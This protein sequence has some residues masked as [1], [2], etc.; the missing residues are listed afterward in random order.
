M[1]FSFT[2][3]E[4]NHP[5]PKSPKLAQNYRHYTTEQDQAPLRPGHQNRTE[6]ITGGKLNQKQCAL[7][8]RRTKIQPLF[9]NE[10]RRETFIKTSAA[11]QG[12]LAG[13]STDQ[14][15]VFVE[16]S[17]E[18]SGHRCIQARWNFPC[19]FSLNQSEIENWLVVKWNSLFHDYQFHAFESIIQNVDWKHGIIWNYFLLL[20]NILI[21]E[22]P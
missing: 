22:P 12:F 11:C 9:V 5:Q 10:S 19:L 17:P 7:L 21:E 3:L 6:P 15:L 8:K 1:L 14:L 18:K 16:L 4:Y 20:Q 2:N 13:K